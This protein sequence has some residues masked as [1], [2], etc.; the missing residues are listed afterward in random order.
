MIV[1]VMVGGFGFGFLFF[2]II[3]DIFL[4]PTSVSLE[5]ENNVWERLPTACYFIGTVIGIVSL[6]GC[7]MLSRPLEVKKLNEFELSNHT[8]LLE[9]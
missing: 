2:G 9:S 4:N 7:Y 6:F 1:C 8:Y 3:I 5:D